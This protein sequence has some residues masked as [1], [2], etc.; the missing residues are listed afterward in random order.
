MTISI[1]L[2]DDHQIILDGIKQMLEGESSICICA[3]A[4]NGK[5]AL[6]LAQ[7]NPP[8]VIITDVSMPDMNGVELCEQIQKMDIPSKVIVLS[9]YASE[10]YIF[11]AIQ[12]GAKGY[13]TKQNTTKE[14]L[15]SAIHQ[16]VNGEEYYSPAVASIMMKNYVNKAQKKS[17]LETKTVESLTTRE[18]EILKLYAEGY[19]NQEIADKLCISNRTVDAH[20]NNIMQKF[21]F[22]STVDMVKFAI[23]NDIVTL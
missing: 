18:R 11:K 16:I 17:N 1:L 9:M 21:E 4:E 2:V 10:D 3:C 19:S 22:K 15:I 5:Q 7:L 8:D 20:K 14:E 13:L 12:A 23:K 6:E